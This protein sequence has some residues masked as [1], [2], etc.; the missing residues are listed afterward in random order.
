M[1]PTP[2]QPHN[3]AKSARPDLAAT[4]LS[5]VFL[6]QMQKKLDVMEEVRSLLRDV[7]AI[8]VPGV[9]VAGAQSSGKSSVI[10]SLCGINLPR[11]ETITTRV[12]LVLRMCADP[13]LEAGC[14]L[15]S[16][17]SDF[18]D[19]NTLALSD[20]GERI[21][22]LTAE[23]AGDSGA[24]QDAPIHVKVTLPQ[25]P[26]LTLIDLPGITHISE[27]GSQVRVASSV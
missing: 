17:H 24:V 13:S 21:A 22:Q 27:E 25:G 11:G 4:P 9:V 7:E 26:T 14:A 3:A 10:E 23:L 12:P 2:A 6:A 20:V 8:S 16:T 1:A 19:A 18:K 15:I 5:D